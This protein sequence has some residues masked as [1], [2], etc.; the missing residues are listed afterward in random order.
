LN[1]NNLNSFLSLNSQIYRIIYIFGTKIVFRQKNIILY[2]IN[3]IESGMK[4][5]AVLLLVTFVT[6][7]VV[8]SCNDKACP[9][10][11]KT[12][13]EQTGQNV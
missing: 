12:D 3:N 13:T 6:A 10:Y 4:K 1:V 9:A 11:S 5:I 2:F 8:S 7:L